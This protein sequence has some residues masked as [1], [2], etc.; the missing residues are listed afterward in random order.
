MHCYNGNVEEEDRVV[1]TTLI[2]LA[3]SIKITQ[4]HEL[5]D[6]KMMMTLIVNC[7][8]GNYPN[9]P[10]TM[11]YMARH[12]R[13]I[14]RIVIQQSN[15]KILPHQ[16]NFF[17]ANVDFITQ[18]LFDLRDRYTV[19]QIAWQ[20]AW[21]DNTVAV[22]SMS[23]PATD[24]TKEL[25]KVKALAKATLA[26]TYSWWVHAKAQSLTASSTVVANRYYMHLKVTSHREKIKEVWS[27]PHEVCCLKTSTKTKA[28][29]LSLDPKQWLTRN[30]AILVLPESHVQ[31]TEKITDVSTK[32]ASLL[33]TWIHLVSC[34]IA[35][36]ALTKQKWEEYF[37]R[38][39]GWPATPLHHAPPSSRASHRWKLSM[40]PRS[41][42]DGTPATDMDPSK[43]IHGRRNSAGESG[44]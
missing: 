14:I 38:H 24:Y 42:E 17:T 30:E 40:C 19:T 9:T 11:H 31:A 22:K 7:H 35:T 29:T 5:G 6:I 43:R 26:T 13:G 21:I 28:N 25:D 23:I 33:S 37:T 27:N 1:W 16:S 18:S 12:V 39:Q 44:E 34:R 20:V 15:I 10:M 4:S 8:E 2:K 41:R 3:L 36:T 32:Q